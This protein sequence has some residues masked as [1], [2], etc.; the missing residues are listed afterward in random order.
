MMEKMMQVLIE[1]KGKVES[2]EDKF[3]SLENK[4]DKNSKD[5]VENGLSIKSIGENVQS[6]GVIMKTNIDNIKSM[7]TDIR[8]SSNRFDVVEKSKDLLLK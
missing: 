1:I 8:K 7:K 2:L 3:E 6:I 4:V 5:V